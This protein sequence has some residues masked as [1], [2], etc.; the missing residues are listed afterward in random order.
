VTAVAEGSVAAGVIAGTQ[1]RRVPI[2]YIGGSGRSGS[3]LIERV[4]G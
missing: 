3:T 4:V 1:P 2:L